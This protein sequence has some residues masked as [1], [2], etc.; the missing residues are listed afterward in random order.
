MRPN[1]GRSYRARSRVLA[2]FLV[3]GSALPAAAAVPAEDRVGS[4]GQEAT[5]A[6]AERLTLKTAGQ[7]L[8]S[9]AGRIWSSPARLRRK[10]VVPL[11]ALAAAT[12]ALI[13]ADEPIVVPLFALA[14]AT[15]A[16]IIADE[17]IRDGV[18][19]FAGKHAWV[20]DIAPVLAE[21]GGL[22]GLGTAG[23]FFGVG[24]IFTDHRA[25]DTG[26]LA[27]SA[28]L[29]CFVVDGFLK[30]MAGRRRPSVADGEDHWYGPTGLFKRFEAGMSDSYVSFPSGHT[31][32]AFSLATVV[33]LQY[34]HSGW[35][36]VAA[37]TIAAG[38]G[39]SR[40]AMDRHWASDVAVGALVGHLVAR[41]V[42]RNH[43]KRRHIVP[44]LA[45]TGRGVALSVFIDLDPADR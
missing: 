27:A 22:A 26:Y 20:G 6:P 19:R 18:Q 21:A 13:I 3:L 33:A 8:L 36:P 35:V 15:T 38:V 23:A 43:N 34:R 44:A 12:T 45:C 42:V 41:L 30:A 40:L 14:A 9:D 28:L 1:R 2:L 24:L 10:D 16:L 37:Y 7:D 39:L 31:A 25:R 4:A 11:F 32:A 29:Q 17:P 5:A